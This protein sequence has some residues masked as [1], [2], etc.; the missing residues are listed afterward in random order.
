M[1]AWFCRFKKKWSS[2]TSKTTSR[3]HSPQTQASPCFSSI[4]MMRSQIT[5]KMNSKT[6]KASSSTFT[7]SRKASKPFLYWR[8][9]R[10]NW[11]LQQI[12][13]SLM[14]LW[15][16]GCSRSWG[17]N[18]S[19]SIPK[20]KSRCLSSS[21]KQWS[22]ISSMIIAWLMRHGKSSITQGQL[23]ALRLRLQ[24]KQYT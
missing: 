10:T 2:S 5:L 23:R 21:Q 13:T 18:W 22:G 19:L 14:G 17:T 1:G 20:S 9:H 11:L 12:S 8:F 7:H 4:S 6:L 15:W 24:E 16:S 3:Y